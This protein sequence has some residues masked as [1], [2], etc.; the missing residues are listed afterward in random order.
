MNFRLYKKKVIISIIIIIAWII[1]LNVYTGQGGCGGCNMMVQC[2]NF[3]YLMPVHLPCACCFSISNLIAFWL[4]I[5]S[6][7]ILTYIIWS[8]FQNKK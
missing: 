7:G 2:Q 4:I 5:M 1:L 6:P 3:S 8:L